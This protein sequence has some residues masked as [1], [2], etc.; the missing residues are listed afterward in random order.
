[1]DR[2]WYTVGMFRH[3]PPGPQPGWKRP[4]YLA[5]TTLLGLIVSFGLHA[6]I[7]LWYL[8]YAQGRGWVIHW[9]NPFGVGLC[10]LPVWL[11]YA[12]PVL[13][14]VVGFL[15][16]RVWWRWVYVERRW[17]KKTVPPA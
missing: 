9:T 7:E 14:L 6:V 3:V 15:V 13:G 16:G 8:W 5:L 12:L 17:E 11:Q 1:M 4:L 10:A 2:L